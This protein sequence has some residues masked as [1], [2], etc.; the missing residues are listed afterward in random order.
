V[1]AIVT[2][3]TTIKGVATVTTTTALT[4][5]LDAGP[6]TWSAYTQYNYASSFSFTAEKPCCFNCTL[7]GGNVQV[8]Y[9]PTAAPASIANSTAPPFRAANSTTAPSAVSTL[10]NSAGFTL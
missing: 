1:E 9:W 10:V 4:T 8:Y 5:S 3:S 6:F 2:I 7:Y